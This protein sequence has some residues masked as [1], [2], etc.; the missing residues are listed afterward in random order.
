M[1]L[2]VWV[3]RPSRARIQRVLA[4]VNPVL[5]GGLSRDARAVHQEIFGPVAVM[6]PFST[7]EEAIDLANDTPYGLAANV[8]SND[9]DQA[10]RIAEQIRAGT[11][12]I[13]GGGSMRPDACVG[14]K[15]DRDV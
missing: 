12:W 9:T 3:I 15:L 14:R 8:W 2:P 13:N 4:A 1:S 11:V 5:L 10:R 7:T 6:M